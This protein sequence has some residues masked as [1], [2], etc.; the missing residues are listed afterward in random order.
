MKL[1]SE[2]CL[3]TTHPNWN[4]KY[5]YGPFSL[6]KVDLSDAYMRV[7][8]YTEDA[9]LRTFVVPLHPSNPEPLIR[10]HLYPPMGYV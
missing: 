5:T 3:G 2:V 8:I 1:S 9:P 10:Y 7:W 4:V 6:T